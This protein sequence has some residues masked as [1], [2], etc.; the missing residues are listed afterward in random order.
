LKVKRTQKLALVGIF[1]ALYA[2]LVYAFPGISFQLVQVRVA[3]ALIP[4]S[5]LFGW[6]V[7][8]GVT[9]GCAVANITSPMPSVV[10][11]IMGGSIANFVAG[12]L[13]LKIGRSDKIRGSEFLGCLAATLV[14]TFIVGTYL[15]I[16]TAIPL[17]LW[18]LSIFIGSFVSI[19]LLGYTL[20]QVLK[21]TKMAVEWG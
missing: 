13:A 11:D 9:I 10:A 14:L 1:A 20:I 6:P 4:L 12:F 8:A 5:M 21:K 18:W 7:I 3:D 16:L 17:W 15:S 19:N 2:T